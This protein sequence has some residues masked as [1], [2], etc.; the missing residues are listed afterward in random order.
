MSTQMDAELAAKYSQMFKHF[1]KFMFTMWRLGLGPLFKLWPEGWGQIMVLTHTGR[2]SAKTYHTPVNYAILNDQVYC[3]AGFGKTADWYRNSCAHPGVEIWLPDGWWAGS[4]EDVSAAAN[5]PEIM[6]AVT[7]ASG[8]A[9][10]LFGVDPK[11][12]DDEALAEATKS[13]KV[14]R[15]RREAART[16]PGGPGDLSWIW[17]LTTMVLALIL[18]TRRKPR[19][20]S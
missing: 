20:R 12:L 14:I 1:N 15:I 5:R 9:G 17:Q 19:R 10:P 4:A 2:V 7:I 13:Y 18:F 11:K 16:G 6:R 3:I 8:F